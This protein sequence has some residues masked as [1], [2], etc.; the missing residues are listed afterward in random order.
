[1]AGFVM[2]LLVGVL[3][4]AGE[5][6]AGYLGVK[7]R[8]DPKKGFFYTTCGVVCAAAWVAVTVTQYAI[9]GTNHAQAY[10]KRRPYS[11]PGLGQA[12]ASCSSSC[13]R[14]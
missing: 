14:V 8:S 4:G 10:Y 12:C 2:P 1:M 3:A 5:G 11:P 13:R 7:A 9:V 6:L